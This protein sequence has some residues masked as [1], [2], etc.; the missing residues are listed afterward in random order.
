VVSES[1][2]PTPGGTGDEEGDDAL[3]NSLRAEEEDD[4]FGD[5]EADLMA[6]FDREDLGSKA[7]DDGAG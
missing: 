7:S 5:L 2:L 4:G 6:E 3:Q 1:S